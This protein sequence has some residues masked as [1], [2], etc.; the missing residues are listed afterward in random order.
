MAEQLS[1]VLLAARTA[2]PTRSLAPLLLGAPELSQCIL[3]LS[4]E[5]L[6]SAV[7][8][9]LKCAQCHLSAPSRPTPGWS[10][11][12]CCRR[13]CPLPVSAFPRTS[14]PQ[15]TS[16]NVL[17]LPYSPSLAALS[18]WAR[19]GMEGQRQGFMGSPAPA[20]HSEEHQPGFSFPGTTRLQPG[21][22]PAEPPRQRRAGASAGGAA[23]FD[24]I[25]HNEQR[26]TSGDA[27]SARLA[28]F[29]GERATPGRR[30]DDW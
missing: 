3:F 8:I 10:S 30:E 22:G 20:A 11:H 16:R 25:E 12:V 5:P 19:Q 7:N 9:S 29:S 18:S 21:P 1:A 28:A 13:A 2:A 14:R 4:T 24:L 23:A 17:A 26:G 15:M 27:P 6:V